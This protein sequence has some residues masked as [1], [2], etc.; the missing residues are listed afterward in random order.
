[1]GEQL[2][3]GTDQRAPQLAITDPKVCRAYLVGN[4]PHDLFTNTKNELGPCPKA[5]NEVLKTE[6]QE[7]DAEQK[8]RWGFEFDY[9]RDM[10]HHIDSCN[11][12]I[13]SA[14]RR[15]EKTPEEIRQT[16]ALVCHVDVHVLVKDAYTI[17]LKA[18]N[19][20][21]KSIEAG[22]LEIQIMGEEGMVNM[23]VQEFTKLRMKKAEKEERERELRAL[24]DTG[25]PSGHQKLQVCD[26]CGA[27][28]SR[29]DNDRRLADHFYGKMHLGYAQMRKSYEALQKDLKGRAPPRDAYTSA[30]DDMNGSRGGQ[31][32]WGGGGYGGGGFGGRGGRRGR[33]RRGGW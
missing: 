30:G 24:S 1:M 23:A 16:N 6:Y 2:M 26:V 12:K 27:Y 4:C 21:T 8:R 22:M 11:R 7:A 18:I 15:L 14:Q 5:H 25:G 28:L 10:Q 3:S 32:G 33:G 29:L 9:M 13:D 31:G 19:E 20:L 17:Q